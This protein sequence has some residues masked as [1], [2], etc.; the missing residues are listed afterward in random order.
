VSRR[1]ALDAIV[2]GAG[3]VGSAAALA[4]ARAGLRV[5][6]VETKAPREWQRDDAPDLRVFA[7][8]PASVRLLRD[9]GVWDA[10]R[11]ARAE[12]YREMRV[13][14]AGGN[15]ELHF[16]ATDTGAD[17]LGYIAEQGAIQHAL[18]QALQREANLSLRC[19][20][21]VT[22]I[23]Q[24]EGDVALDLDDGDRLTARLVIAADGAASPLRQLAGIETTRHDYAQRGIVGFI[25]SEQ[26]HANTAWQ[27][28]LPGGPLAVLPFADGLS[29]IVWTVSDAEAERL[30]ALDDAAFANELTRAFDARLGEM[31]CASPRAAFP[32]RMQL[33]KRYVAGRLV[34]IG[35]AAHVV[36]PL[37]GQGVNLGLQDVRELRDLI[38]AARSNGRDIGAAQ[39]LRRYER[40][41]RSDNA[42]A[43]RTFDGLNRLFSNDAFVPT[44][45]RGPALGLVNRIAPLKQLFARH[46]AGE[47]G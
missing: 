40:A 11:A 46:A 9:L 21:S 33:A 17:T 47:G 25:R 5:A 24:N 19:P 10:I 28:F 43:A 8:A 22:G 42:L 30:L 20:A 18:W 44:L 4:L 2:V 16:R 1:A 26:P 31:S 36:H 37:A 34:L 38:A 32:L 23:E 12:P 35:D 29:S 3:V 39:L 13:W 14:D 41:R 45:L 27:R 15:D 6:L 7:I